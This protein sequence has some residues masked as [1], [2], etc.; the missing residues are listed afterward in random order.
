MQAFK[1]IFILPIFFLIFGVSSKA[2]SAMKE[3]LNIGISSEF[4]TLNP[5]IASQAATKYMLYLAYRP[6]VVLSLDNKW[7]AMLIKDVPTIENKMVKRVGEGLEINFEIIE[8]AKWGDGKPVTCKDIEFAW[9]L[10]LSPNVSSSNRE[11]FENIKKITW[12]EKN[13]KKCQMVTAKAK[14]SYFSDMPDPMPE[15]LEGP[16]FQKFKDQKEGYD[17][18]TLYTK[19]PSNPG[20]YNGPYM[21]SEVKLGSHVVFVQNPNFYGKKPYFKKIIFKLIPNN[22]TLTANLRSGNID[23]I[24]PAGGLGIDQAVAFEKT[25]KQEN[26]PFQVVFADG[27]IYAHIDLNLEHPALSDLR[28]R[29]ALLQSFSK[30]EIIDS[31][32][33]GK[34]KAAT[35][36]V[37]PGD[38]WG[39][40]VTVPVPGF[41][42]KAANKLLEEAGWTMGPKGIRMKDGKSLSFTIMAASGAKINE[43]IETY[44]QAQWKSIGVEI[45]IKNEP[46]RVFF[47]ETTKKRKFDLALYSWVSIPEGSP[48]S[49][50]HSSMIP[51]EANA[52][53][54]QNQPGYK[55]AEVDKL[56]DK[57]EN[58]LGSK[59]RADLANKVV[60]FYIK[61]IPV[62][63][64]YYRPNNSVIRKEMQG[65][66][67]S[68]HLYYES[69]YAEDWH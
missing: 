19:D 55:N 29:K 15:H 63:P 46:A 34:A 62:I 23:L 16:V 43:M 35:S 40:K 53:S 26:L 37:A 17:L 38:S 3:D 18:N 69:L 57:L 60:E 2:F 51:T 8:K 48:R 30:Q 27:L 32:M 41:D 28:V 58:E 12:N 39:N 6:T 68:G 4:E 50:L 54:G 14:Y 25:V 5:L 49:T 52:W 44:L 13:P 22:A 66:K 1:L 64:I 67:L 10:G 56:I 45:S 20:L 36:F 7:K 61:D 11:P 33:E 31:L 42:K 24:C 59:K 47:G 9:Q 65:Y 21:I